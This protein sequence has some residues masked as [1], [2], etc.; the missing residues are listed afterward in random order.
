MVEFIILYPITEY[1]SIVIW[2]NGVIKGGAAKMF[3]EIS[4]NERCG[5][6][7]QKRSTY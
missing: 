6:L 4:Q 1:F 2:Q 5:K 3:V 7:W